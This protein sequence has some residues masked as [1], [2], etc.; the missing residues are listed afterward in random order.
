[1]VSLPFVGIVQPLP[2]ENVAG[3]VPV[4]LQQAA[5]QIPFVFVVVRVPEEAE[6]DVPLPEVVPSVEVEVDVPETSESQHVAASGAEAMV[7]VAL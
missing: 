7:H 3:F 2:I 6:V 1:L 4:S 5:H